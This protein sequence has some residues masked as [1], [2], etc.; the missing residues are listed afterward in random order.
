LLS[1]FWHWQCLANGPQFTRGFF[2][3]QEVLLD[4][5]LLPGSIW[6]QTPVIRLYLPLNI[7]AHFASLKCADDLRVYQG[8]LMPLNHQACMRSILKEHLRASYLIYVQLYFLWCSLQFMY[9]CSISYFS[10]TY[11]ETAKILRDLVL[12]LNTINRSYIIVL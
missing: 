2:L 6:L 3:G 11:E 9:S 7:R 5:D 12:T 8:F 10:L 1:N 4:F